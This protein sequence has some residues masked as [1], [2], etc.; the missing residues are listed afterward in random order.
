M[1]KYLTGISVAIVA[2]FFG[3]CT[4]DCPPPQAPPMQVSYKFNHVVNKIANDLINCKA[5]QKNKNLPFV[6]T[7]FVNLNNFKETSNF[8]RMVSETLM[9]ELVKKSIK[10]IDY[11]GQNAITVQ[12]RDGE[13]FLSRVASQL[14]LQVKNAYI[15]VG[16]YTSYGNSIVANVR[17]IDNKTGEV[18]SA[19]DIIIKDPLLL[20]EVCVNGLCKKTP[21]TPVRTIKIQKDICDKAGP[22]D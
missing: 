7:S 4:K 20:K 8:G 3:G 6:L 5:V 2:L 21:P 22:C 10:V 1:K 17:L 12:K 19:S 15:V 14:K 18:V 11:R 13:F 16:T 9:S